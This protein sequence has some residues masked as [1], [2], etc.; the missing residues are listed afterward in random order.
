MLQNDGQLNLTEHFGNGGYWNQRLVYQR[1]SLNDCVET[2][3]WI[4]SVD[5]SAHSTV[6][7]HQRIR[8][9]EREVQV[10]SS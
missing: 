1:A 10:S 2:V 5:H 9:Y 8:A 4:S 7:L 6:R 3:D